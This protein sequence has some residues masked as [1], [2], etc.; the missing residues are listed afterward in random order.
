MIVIIEGPDGAGKTTFA[1]GIVGAAYHHEGQPPAGAYSLLGYYY[2]KVAAAHAET[3][4]PIVFDRLALGELVYGPILRGGARLT[5]S[6]Y[7]A[8]IKETRKL[9]AVHVLCLPPKDCAR[10]NWKRRAAVG[11]ELFEQEDLFNRTYDAFAK[12]APLADV[13]YDYTVGEPS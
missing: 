9:G 3:Q 2:G 10:T 8:F 11:G 4:G 5:Y 13:V 6:D 12:F 1:K 7:A